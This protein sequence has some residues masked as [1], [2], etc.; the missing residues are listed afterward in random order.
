MR[1]LQETGEIPVVT[2]DT[3][4]P[5][6]TLPAPPAP[7]AKATEPEP[8]TLPAPPALPAKATE[9]E[10]PTLPAP[11]APP[12]KATE[13]A[14]PT[15]PAPPAPP[16]KAATV[17]ADHPVRRR[18]PILPPQ[19]TGSTPVIDPETGTIGAIS[20]SFPAAVEEKKPIVNLPPLPPV[21]DEPLD[22]DTILSGGP[23]PAD[24]APQSEPAPIPEAESGLPKRA[25]LFGKLNEDELIEGIE[26]HHTPEDHRELTVEQVAVRDHANPGVTFL[27]YLVLVLA[28]FVLGG[29]I[30]LIADS[31]SASEIDEGVASSVTQ[32]SIR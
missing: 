10:P 29:M 6:P 25:S 18:R 9:P 31:A 20:M 11:P 26:D 22:F 12:A 17:E 4:P 2:A 27:R 15:L 19:T 13:P 32:G 1:L 8:P 21:A 14:A 7:P 3:P 5:A 24:V 23:A 30:W 16:A 28:M